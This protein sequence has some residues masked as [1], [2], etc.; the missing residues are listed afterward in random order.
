MVAERGCR[1]TWYCYRDTDS[2]QPVGGE[3]NSLHV[4]G[5]PWPPEADGGAAVA[6]RREGSAVHNGVWVDWSGWTVRWAANFGDG[7]PGD[8]VPPAQ[9]TAAAGGLACV[10]AYAT[11]ALGIACWNRIS[12]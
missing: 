5:V 7:G 12:R 1:V 3:A 10:A 4:F 8:V 9:C 2:S 11:V 6:A